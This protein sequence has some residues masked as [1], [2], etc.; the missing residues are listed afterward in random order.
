M[1]TPVAVRR[2]SAPSEIA[3][4]MPKSVTIAR[5]SSLFSRMLSGLMSRWTTEREWARLNA[6]ATSRMTRRTSLTSIGPVPWMRL[7]RL[8]PSTYCITKKTR[9]SFSSTE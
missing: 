6:E 9:P 5:P 4:A 7:P 2:E 8:S 3:R 1:A